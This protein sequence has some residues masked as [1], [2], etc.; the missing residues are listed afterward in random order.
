MTG[1]SGAVRLLRVSEDEQCWGKQHSGVLLFVS[2]AINSISKH[3]KTSQFEVPPLSPGTH[4]KMLRKVMFS[5]RFSEVRKFELNH[6]PTPFLLSKN[7][8]KLTHILKFL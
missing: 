3:G 4:Q 2:N 7:A 1:V 5:S 8:G 6:I